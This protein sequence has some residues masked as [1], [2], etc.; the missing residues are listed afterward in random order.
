MALLDPQEALSKIDIQGTKGC[1]FNRSVGVKLSLESLF[2]RCHWQPLMHTGP[3]MPQTWSYCQRL[4][5]KPIQF[6]D[7]SWKLI[8][9]GKRSEEQ[10]QADSVGKIPS[11]SCSK[12]LLSLAGSKGIPEMED[13][14][15]SNV[16][17]L[18]WETWHVWW[19]QSPGK[20]WSKGSYMVC[21]A[22]QPQW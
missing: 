8:H 16:R 12:Y 19:C 15:L 1:V 5:F 18:R 17:F 2:L 6:H 13:R 4:Q 3:D 20:T 22:V 9:G 14:P 21:I 11:R 7:F 10:I